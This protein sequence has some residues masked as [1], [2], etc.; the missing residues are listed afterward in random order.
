MKKRTGLFFIELLTVILFFALFS[1]VCLR[2]FA[3][4]HTMTAYN[5]D[6]SN[7]VAAAQNTAECFKAAG[8]DI[9]LTAELLNSGNYNIN[10]DIKNTLSYK[11]ATNITLTLTA[12]PSS[13]VTGAV[14]TVADREDKKIF[15]LE[16]I[17]L[18]KTGVPK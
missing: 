18:H 13:I 11:P 7:A 10:L 5:S 15:E 1:A 17:A 6:K 9:V 14:I 16:I 12:Q 2:L 4:A 3:F 8:G